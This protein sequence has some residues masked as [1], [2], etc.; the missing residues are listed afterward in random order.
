M[1]SDFATK[2]TTWNLCS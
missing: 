2:L 1:P